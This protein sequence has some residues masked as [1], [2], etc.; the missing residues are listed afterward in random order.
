[1]KALELVKMKSVNYHGTEVHVPENINFI[2]SDKSGQTIGFVGQPY[3]DDD[4]DWWDN[5][6]GDDMY[7]IGVFDLEGTHW[8]ETLVLL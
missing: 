3:P 8:T 5:P 1:M 2:A 7:D 4:F 6:N